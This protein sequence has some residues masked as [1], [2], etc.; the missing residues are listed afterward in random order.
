LYGQVFSLF[1]FFLQP[2]IVFSR[3]IHL[4]A[5]LAIETM[6]AR[7]AAAVTVTA[8]TNDGNDVWAPEEKKSC[9]RMH[10]EESK[11]PAVV[12]AAATHLTSV[13]SRS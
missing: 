6:S 10:A 9:V 4:A 8:A 11:G 7:V 13:P 2:A 1:P 5:F 3:I 12:A